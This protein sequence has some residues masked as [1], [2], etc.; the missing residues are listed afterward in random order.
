LQEFV[1]RRARISGKRRIGRERRQWCC[2]GNVEASHAVSVSGARIGEESAT[3]VTGVENSKV[4]GPPSSETTTLPECGGNSPSLSENP[5]LRAV[6]FE[7]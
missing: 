7:K 3:C 2:R 6:A 5:A 1:G 4:I